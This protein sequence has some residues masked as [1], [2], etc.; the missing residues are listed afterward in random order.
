M[1]VLLSKKFSIQQNYEMCKEI[2]CDPFLGEKKSVESAWI[3]PDVENSRPSFL[4]SYYKYV[5][6]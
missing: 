6:K 3:F 5:K 2:K 1:I 4:S